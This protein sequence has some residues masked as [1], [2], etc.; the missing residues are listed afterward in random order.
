MKELNN[1]VAAI[2]GAASGI[3]Q[4]LA[5]NLADKGCEV[6][7]SDV[8]MGGLEKTAA[9]VEKHNGN[10]SIYKVDVADRDQVE[11]Y[12]ADV[13]KQHDRVDMIINNAGVAVAQSIDDVSYDDFKWLNEVTCLIDPKRDD[14][15]TK[16]GSK[17]II[18]MSSLEYQTAG[19]E[20]TPPP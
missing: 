12:A 4:M 13:V 5:V 16:S 15:N 2:T 1:K 3:G 17:Q 8:D 20:P 6:A 18:G 7:I 11:N 10:V 9:M 14:M 19:Q